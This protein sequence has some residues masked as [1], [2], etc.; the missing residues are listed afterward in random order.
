MIDSRD[1]S[2]EQRIEELFYSQ[3]AK[4]CDKLGACK[5]SCPIG[6]NPYEAIVDIKEKIEDFKANFGEWKA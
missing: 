6:I 4:H 2:F 1:E 5:T 3:E